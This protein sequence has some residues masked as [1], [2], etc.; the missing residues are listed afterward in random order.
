MK[1]YY[2]EIDPFCCAWIAELIRMG[3]LPDG[4]IDNRSI[5][6][7]R[8][9]ELI[10]YDQCHFFTGIA[11]WPL[12]LKQA[13]WDGPVWTGSCPCQSFSQAGKRKGFADERHLWPVWFKLIS[14]CRPPVVFGEQ[15]AGSAAKDW[16]DLVCSD[17]ERVGYRGG[18]HRLPQLAATARRISDKDCTGWHT[19]QCADVTMGSEKKLFHT[20]VQFSLGDQVLLA[21]WPTP[22]ARDYMDSPNQ[23]ETRKDGRS[24]LDVLSTKAMSLVGK[25]QGPCRLTASGKILTGSGAGIKNGGRLNP[26]LS[27]WLMGFPKAWCIAAIN[28]ARTFVPLR[29]GSKA[30]AMR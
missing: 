6:D 9:D 18:G 24:K 29:K 28:A 16:F 14:Q 8:P 12:A 11:G 23:K 10:G 3:E 26:A 21:G 7:V 17:L 2:N 15:V 4:D 27:R 25:V 13:G 20:T 19:P 5:E 1:V 30:T 22:C